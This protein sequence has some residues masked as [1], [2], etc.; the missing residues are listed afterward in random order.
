[1]YYPDYWKVSSVIPVFNN[2]GERFMAKDYR[3]VSLLSV[4]SNI[5]EKLVKN[6]LV[7]RLE[8]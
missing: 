3:T 4:V 6:R 2:V 1:M 5:F 7:D 8:K